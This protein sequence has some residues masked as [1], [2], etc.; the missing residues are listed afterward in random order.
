MACSDTL[1]STVIAPASPFVQNGG[2]LSKIFSNVAATVQNWQRRRYDRAQLRT[3]P[4]YLLR[5]VGLDVATARKEVEKPF[6]QA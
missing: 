2:A 6:W 3:M 5:D 4:D 1:T